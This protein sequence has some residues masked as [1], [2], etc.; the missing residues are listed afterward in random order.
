MSV[1]IEKIGNKIH[2][3]IPYSPG[4]V[5]FCR[6]IRGGSWLRAK[7]RWVFPLFMTTYDEIIKGA[8]ARQLPVYVGLDLNDWLDAERERLA[9]APKS[10]S[11]DLVPLPNVAMQ[12]EFMLE[13]IQSRPFQTVGASFIAHHRECL[14]ADE[15]GLGKTVQT[16]AAIVEADVQGPILIIAPK[17]AAELTWPR[18]IEYWLNAE[19][20]YV[21]N[22]AGLTAAQRNAKLDAFWDATEPGFTRTKRQWLIVNPYWLMVKADLDAKGNYKANLR[23]RMEGIGV[24]RKMPEL[25][26]ID[27]NAIIIDESHE[28]LIVPSMNKK[29]WTQWRVGIDM[30]TQPKN[31]LRIALSGTPARG[32]K[33]Q[34]FGTLNWL[35]PEQYSNYYKWAERYF[36]MY[37]D[38]WSKTKQ[39]GELIREK[40]LYADLSEVMIR[41]TK[42][43]VAKDLPPII[44]GGELLDKDN[45][46]SPLGVWLD[47]LPEQRK[48]YKQMERDG[49]MHTATGTV[50]ANG[51]LA[52]WTRFK[53]I[54]NA[55]GTA[56][57]NNEGTAVYNPNGK[58]A[59]VDWI[60]DF[61]DH[62]GI[63]GKSIEGTGKVI[64][65]SQFATFCN[66]ITDDIRAAGAQCFLLTGVTPSKERMAMERE[67]QEDVDNP[68]AC[69]VFVLSTKAAGVSLTLDAADDVIIC[70]ETWIPDDQDQIEAR[71]HR[72]SRVDHQVF[73]WY[74][75]MLGTIEEAVAAVTAERGMSMKAILDGARGVDTARES[76][77]NYKSKRE[78]A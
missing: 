48:L 32:K 4:N 64:I 57:L 22:L 2:L 54:A 40:E 15:M 17:I 18:Q 6:S 78:A 20:E 62:K 9:N 1:R 76:I 60:M 66:R 38:D 24:E 58:S 63:I 75:R 71:A 39:I 12:N 7:R 29:K 21:C 28:V 16:L 61:L 25:F 8:E 3:Q 26:M 74:L 51:L 31:G 69:R 34:F 47:M 19:E 67:W 70:D 30:L 33:E 50:M 5:E 65:A 53:Q 45:P 44:Y 77:L 23:Q 43:E 68:N 35:R 52:E 13:A 14:I 42:A 73:V 11:L 72:V 46:K 37:T 56:E 49:V 27:W 41:R 55:A 59:K 10:S 36:S